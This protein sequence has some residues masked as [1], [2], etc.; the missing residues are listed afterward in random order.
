MIAPTISNQLTNA[1]QS[2]QR[3]SQNYIWQQEVERLAT[4]RPLPDLT[5]KQAAANVKYM[6]HDMTNQLKDDLKNDRSLNG[7]EGFDSYVKRYLAEKYTNPKTHD[8]F[9]KFMQDFDR[10]ASLICSAV[11]RLDTR[12][13]VRL[14]PNQAGQIMKNYNAA[15]DELDKAFTG[16]RPKTG[17]MTKAIEPDLKDAVT[18]NY[19]NGRLTDLQNDIFDTNQSMQRYPLPTSEELT[20]EVNVAQPENRLVLDKK[21]HCVLP[22]ID[23]ESVDP[24]LALNNQ[25]QDLMQNTPSF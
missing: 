5:K 12:I 18:N 10:F 3:N 4:I 22:S 25:K 2:N 1:V 19:Q 9:I 21:G 23:T 13:A 24:A 17:Q 20:Q 14:H 6:Q 15:Q 16:G 8:Q 7:K 11:L